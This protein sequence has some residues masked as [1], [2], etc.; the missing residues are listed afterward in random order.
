MKLL[1]YFPLPLLMLAVGCASF[2]NTAFRTEQTLLAAS[3][4]ALHAYN[5]YYNAATN[6]L[7]DTNKLAHLNAQRAQVLDEARKFGAVAEV[8]NSALESYHVNSADTNKTAVVVAAQIFADESTN[9]VNLVKFFIN[10][11]NPSIV[12]FSTL[13]TPVTPVNH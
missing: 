11:N 7:V 8:Y 1:K 9:I 10:P 4:T 3:T 6:G 13:P 12:T 5:T 2:Y